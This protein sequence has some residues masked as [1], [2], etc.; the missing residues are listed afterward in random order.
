MKNSAGLD[1]TLNQT[2][3]ANHYEKNTFYKRNKNYTTLQW[4]DVENGIN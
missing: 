4:V 2:G 3:I 1:I